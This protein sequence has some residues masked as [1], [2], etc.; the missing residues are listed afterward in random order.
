MISNNSTSDGTGALTRI[1]VCRFKSAFGH[2]DAFH[3]PPNGECVPFSNPPRRLRHVHA[4]K[5]MCAFWLRMLSHIQN[6]VEVTVVFGVRHVH[7][8]GTHLFERGRDGTLQAW[9]ASGGKGYAMNPAHCDPDAIVVAGFPQSGQWLNQ[10]RMGFYNE[11]LYW[12]DAPDREVMEYTDWAM[13]RFQ[14]RIR[15]SCD[16]RAMRATIVEG[17]DADAQVIRIA[18]RLDHGRRKSPEQ[19]TIGDYNHVVAH[20]QAYATL[21]AETPQFISLFSLVV[22]A[23]DFPTSGQPTQRL[24]E[25][26]LANGG[27]PALWRLLAKCNGRLITTFMPFY[28]QEFFTLEFDFFRILQ[29]L[30]FRKAPPHWFLWDVMQLFGSPNNQRT[31]Y[32]H[33]LSRFWV[34]LQRITQLLER[35]NPDT[36]ESMRT[37]LHDVLTWLHETWSPAM[38]RD[39]RDVEW[40]WF[41]TRAQHWGTATGML[42]RSRAMTWTAPFTVWHIERYQVVPLTSL[43]ALWRE[44]RSMRHCADIHAN[45]CMQRTRLVLSVRESGR[46][47]AVFTV[48]L[49]R[50]NDVWQVTQA[51]GFANKSLPRVLEPVL[52]AIKERV[53]ALP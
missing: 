42:A 25:H 36:I 7:I 50:I 10:L 44:A 29:S 41:L 18:R 6:P 16:L 11:L 12:V 32:A 8:L 38:R 1:P 19:V 43:H 30:R 21:A 39:V 3:Q 31:F 20:R 45:D 52:E 15:R 22:D 27:T 23:P 24:R 51:S 34:P 37:H 49:R 17:L 47:R 5:F 28:E 13:Q 14:A 9:I 53:A 33:S 48:M 46:H 40:A 4:P 35:A 2:S 26:L